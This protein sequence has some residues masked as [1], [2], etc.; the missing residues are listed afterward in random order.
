MSLGASIEVCSRGRNVKIRTGF[1]SNSSS[2]SFVVSLW[3]LTP[4][5]VSKIL[6]HQKWGKKLGMEYTEDAWSIT[7]GKGLVRG[8]TSMD[9]FDMAEFLR[10]IGVT[11]SSDQWSEWGDDYEHAACYDSGDCDVCLMRFLCYTT[12]W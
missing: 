8:E 12:E 1:V 9:N 7:L 6:D 3:K 11:T 4:E 5:Q 2:S 10:K